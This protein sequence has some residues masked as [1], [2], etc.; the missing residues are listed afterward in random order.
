[1]TNTTEHPPTL[2]AENVRLRP[3]RIA[4]AAAVYE[5]LRDPVVTALTSYPDVS[6][7]MVEG[8]IERYQSRWAAGELSKWGIALAA[9]DN[10]VGI[11]GFNDWSKAHRWAEVGFD[12]ARAHW[13]RGLMRQAL[14][15]LLE[16]TYQ[17]D[18]LDRI[19]AYVRVDNTRSERL[20]LRNGFVREGCLR[21]YRVCRGQPH[22]FYIFS[23]LRADWMTRST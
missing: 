7:S 5:Y 9:D 23:L 16:W 4:D 21:N 17:R 10:I 22:H 12:L 20:L 1:M 13:G 6:L 18:D 19:H 3:L 2:E 15:A 14:E 8:M 11:C